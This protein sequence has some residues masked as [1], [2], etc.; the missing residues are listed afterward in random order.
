MSQIVIKRDANLS[1]PTIITRLIEYGIQESESDNSESEA[2]VTN[3]S[4]IKT[5]GIIHPLMALNG[6]AVDDKDIISFSLSNSINPLPACT[7]SFQDRNGY[8]SD[9]TQPTGNNIFQIQILPPWD[10]VYEKINLMFYCTSLST[11]GGIVSGTGEY[12]LLDLTDSKLC[13]FGEISTYEFFDKIS[14]ETGLGF[15][16]NVDSTSDTRYIYCRNQ[17]LKEKIEEEIGMAIADESQ[18]YDW[19]IDLWNNIVLCNIYERF[20]AIDSEDDL[21]MIMPEKTNSALLDDAEPSQIEVLKVFNNHANYENTDLY[22]EKYNIK[23]NTYL[24][25]YAGTTRIITAYSEETKDYTD[26]IIINSDANDTSDFIACEYA[27]EY[28]GSY[29]YLISKGLR[30]VF[31]NKMNARQLIISVPSA[32]L[33]ITRGSQLRVVWYDNQSNEKILGD[34]FSEN[35]IITE[36]DLGW[37]S[38]YI[39]AEKSNENSDINPLSVNLEISGQYLVT[40]INI[41]YA[42]NSWNTDIILVRPEENIPKQLYGN[43]ESIPEDEIE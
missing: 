39:E 9:L 40:G 2:S 11:S 36:S 33:A 3:I 1:I 27:G 12:K 35:G 24:N 18:I 42:D 32:S 15:A 25:Y 20:N 30:D 22:I 13:A 23:N 8:F 31:L 14:S 7:F 5:V 10:G 21:T 41:N 16:S 29:N 26:N 34:V 17:S 28:Y 19:W 38:E 4:Q 6:V 43:I 37:L